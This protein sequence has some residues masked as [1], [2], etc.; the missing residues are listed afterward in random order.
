[1]RFSIVRLATAAV[2]TLA[3]TTAGAQQHEMKKG[4]SHDMKG[5]AMSPWKEMD[6]FHAVLGG[7]FHPVEK[8]DFAPLKANAATLAE[9]ASA[10]K[11]STAPAACA[12]PESKQTVEWLAS[13]TATLAEQVKSGAADAALK[14][15]ITE[16]HDKFEVVEKSCV[17][18][19]DM[20]GMKH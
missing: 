9:K 5:H 2:I 1:M 16:I 17:S 18:K 4:E 11:S 19:H 3:A 15:A 7:T 8:G 10:W 14:S 20:K 12:S 13:S 6:A